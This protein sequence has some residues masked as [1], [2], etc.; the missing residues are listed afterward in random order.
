MGK[1]K[2]KSVWENVGKGVSI[3][4][5]KERSEKGQHLE[6]SVMWKAL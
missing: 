2:W 6:F 5:R 3:G 4:A 1:N